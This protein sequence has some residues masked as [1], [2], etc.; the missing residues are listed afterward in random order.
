MLTAPSLCF[1]RGDTP[2][3]NRAWDAINAGAV[4][5]FIRRLQ[6]KVFAFQVYRQQFEISSEKYPEPSATEPG[7][8]LAS[9]AREGW[10]A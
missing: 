10:V 5:V 2:S 8:A 3:S 4:P 7:C 9:S 1:A 6:F